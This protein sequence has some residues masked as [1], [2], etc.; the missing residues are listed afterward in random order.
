MS[1]GESNS[2]TTSALIIDA[3]QGREDRSF[4]QKALH[5]CPAC[6]QVQRA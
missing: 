6:S 1:Y 5:A 4:G 3:P 2:A